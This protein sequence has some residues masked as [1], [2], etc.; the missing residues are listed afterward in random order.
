MTVISL[1]REEGLVCGALNKL[2]VPLFFAFVSDGRSWLANKLTGLLHAAGM[3]CS[4]PQGNEP[5]Q[6]LSNLE[7]AEG[8]RLT[9][10]AP[11]SR[12]VAALS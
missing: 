9:E 11:D 10:A 5:Q 4:A 2:N 8:Q 7:M 12:S 6:Q 1:E 3:N